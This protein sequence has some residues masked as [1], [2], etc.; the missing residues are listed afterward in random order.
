MD[1]AFN[2]STALGRPS[3]TLNTI[4]HASPA[5]RIAAAVPRVATRWN[6]SA[7]NLRATATASGLWWSFTLM[8]TVPLSGSGV[9]APICALANASPK[10][11]PTPIT[12]PVDRISGPSAGSTPGNLLNGNTG[13]FTKY[14]GT[15]STPVASVKSRIFLPSISPTAIFGSATPVALLTYGTVRDARGFTSNTY[16]LPF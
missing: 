15:G 6:H 4:L 9:P 16:T 14:C 2:K 10:L 8:N 12:S 7:A 5:A 1:P 11:A 3:F 13:D